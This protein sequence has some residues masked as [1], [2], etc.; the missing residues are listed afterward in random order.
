MVNSIGEKVGFKQEKLNRL[1]IKVGRSNLC[2]V[3]ALKLSIF[4]KTRFNRRRPSIDLSLIVKFLTL[5]LFVKFVHHFE[6]AL[7]LVRHMIIIFK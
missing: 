1:I 2:F 4:N 6:L 7:E 5:T 3:N